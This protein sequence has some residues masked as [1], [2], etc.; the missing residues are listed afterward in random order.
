MEQFLE[1]APTA[2]PRS[3][4]G[5]ETAKATE[6]ERE[7]FMAAGFHYYSCPTIV[8]LSSQMFPGPE[9]V[10]EQKKL[11]GVQARQAVQQRFCFSTGFR[12]WP[13][14]PWSRGTVER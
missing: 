3:P 9:Q 11:P 14:E 7:R 2:P 6:G 8:V 5:P 13:G 4:K 12:F 1:N 10:L